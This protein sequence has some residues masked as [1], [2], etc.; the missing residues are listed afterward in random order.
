[1]A[2]LGSAAIRQQHEK[3]IMSDKKRHFKWCLFIH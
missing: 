2:P 1:M 3:K